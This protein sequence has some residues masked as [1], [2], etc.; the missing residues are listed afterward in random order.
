[1]AEFYDTP[2]YNSS[3]VVRETGL[4]ADT[5]RAWERRFGVPRPSRTPGGHRQYSEKDIAIVQWLLARQEEGMRISRAVQLLN[6]L[7]DQ[8]QD[9]FAEM[10]TPARVVQ[11]RIN[12]GHVNQLDDLRNAWVEACLQFD[13]TGTEQILTQA[14]ALFPAEMTCI[15]V[16]H[17]GLAQIGV[18]ARQGASSAPQEHFASALAVRRLHCLIAATAPPT[19]SENILV[20]CPPHEERT[21]APLLLTLMLRRRGLPV[22]YLGADVPTDQ[23]ADAIDQIKPRLM[24][25]SAQ[26]LSTAAALLEAASALAEHAMA[27]AYSGRIFDLHPKIQERIPGHY[28]GADFR[29]AIVT[30]EGLLHHPRP[31]PA[32]VPR[33][34]AYEQTLRVFSQKRAAI[35]AEIFAQVPEGSMPPSVVQIACESLSSNI[36]AALKLGNMKL[37]GEETSW[38]SEMLQH[39]TLDNSYLKSFFQLYAEAVEHQ[40]GNEGRIVSEWFDQR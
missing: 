10:V 40:L 2:L 26:Q 3:V 37:L 14:F 23:L 12:L 22:T 36:A 31:A 18:M 38:G 25:F 4:K 17:A 33:T 28:L 27:V 30:T 8:G 15:E 29:E 20:A 9:P 16:L 34:A 19:R 5:L 11:P 24:I 7:Q 6:H 1:M 32:A 39:R 21:F 13:E 35:T